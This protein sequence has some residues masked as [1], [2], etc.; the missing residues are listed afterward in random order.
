MCSVDPISGIALIASGCNFLSAEAKNRKVQSNCEEMR[1]LHAAREAENV[2]REQANLDRAR[3]VRALA[4]KMSGPEW[5]E[6]ARR[7]QINTAVSEERQRAEGRMQSLQKELGMMREELQQR[8]L[9]L[10]EAREQVHRSENETAAVIA[11]AK[12]KLVQAN[13]QV[14][15]TSGQS[16]ELMRKLQEMRETNRKA[17]T[18]AIRA[19]NS[20]QSAAAEAAMLR[21][22]LDGQRRGLYIVGAAICIGVAAYGAYRLYQKYANQPAVEGVPVP[23]AR[24]SEL[25]VGE[26]LEEVEQR[27]RSEFERE[28]EWVRSEIVIR[29][30]LA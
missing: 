11:S 17:V 25:G 29:F 23:V 3:E 14:R 10:A 27:E 5:E 24:E 21:R 19:R 20:Q 30:A 4:A 16:A 7:E 2:E 1:Q 28:E 22:K 8:E 13:D 12:D 6:L 9:E 26:L 15:K 18:A